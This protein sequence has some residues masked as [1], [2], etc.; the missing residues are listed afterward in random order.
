MSCWECEYAPKTYDEFCIAQ[1]NPT[2][3]CPDAY[4]E[5]SH[6][7]GNYDIKETDKAESEEE[8]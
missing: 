1:A 8:E 3:Y 6:L 7:C 4:T 5:I 2:M